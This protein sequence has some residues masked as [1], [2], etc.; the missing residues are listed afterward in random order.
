MMSFLMLVV[1]GGLVAVGVVASGA[2]LGPFVEGYSVTIALLAPAAIVMIGIPPRHAAAAIR[3][4]LYPGAA[5]TGQLEEAAVALETWRRALNLTAG[6]FPL[7][8]LVA[9]LV[10]FDPDHNSLDQ[11]AQGVATAITVTL[12]V[13]MLH[14]LVV[15]PLIGRVHHA[16]ARLQR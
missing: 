5:T 10:G 13:L 1:L 4:A 8:G 9:M 7:I 2:G 3:H 12:Y 14:A 16:R 6:I 15:R 11:V